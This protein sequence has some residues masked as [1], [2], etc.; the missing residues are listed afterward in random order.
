MVRYPTERRRSLSELASERIIRPAGGGSGSG[1][2]TE[3]PLSTVAR[4]TEK[5][6]P[7]TLT[8][9]DGK[10]AALV[11]GRADT[12]TIT[13]IQ[14]RRQIGEEI[15]TNIRKCAPSNS[16]FLS[17]RNESSGI[18]WTR[19]KQ[20]ASTSVRT[21]RTGMGFTSIL[22]IRTIRSCTP[23][24]PASRCR[25]I[26]RGS[27]FTAKAQH[28]PFFEPPAPILPLFINALR[29]V[30]PAPSGSPRS[31]KYFLV[32]LNTIGASRRRPMRFGTA[33]S[34]LRVSDRFQTK[35][36]LTLANESAAAIHSTR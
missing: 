17:S 32:T 11:N 2:Y 9:I 30:Q 21:S 27:R 16:V 35:S 23:P 10:Q 26:R 34:P 20:P 4:L 14:A 31:S 22:R 5:R 25:R 18:W 8:R 6:G 29:D 24:R 36:T 1:A 3:V 19:V 12:A 13:P 7:A 28:R 15:I 33:I